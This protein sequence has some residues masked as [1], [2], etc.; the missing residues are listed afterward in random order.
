M[1]SRETVYGIVLCYDMKR[2]KMNFMWDPDGPYDNELA[3]DGP[4]L[5]AQPTNLWT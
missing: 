1:K 4:S 2:N 3:L 5:I